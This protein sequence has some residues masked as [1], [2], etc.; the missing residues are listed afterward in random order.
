MVSTVRSGLEQGS[1][2]VVATPPYVSARHEAQQ[3]AL[4]E[5][6][7]KEFG[8]EPRFQYV[9]LGRAIDL[10]DPSFSADGV[11][12]TP[13]GARVLATRLAEAMLERVRARIQ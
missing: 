13:G 3:R 2:V 12:P 10:R 11:Y 9:D 6:L 8:G 7:M 4:A 5:V 1:H